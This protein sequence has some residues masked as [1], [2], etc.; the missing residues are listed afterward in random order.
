MTSYRRMACH[1]Q[2]LARAKHYVRLHALETGPTYPDALEVEMGRTFKEFMRDVSRLTVKLQ[3]IRI[4]EP[5]FKTVR[6]DSWLKQT[7]PES[8]QHRERG[9]TGAWE[10]HTDGRHRRCAECREPMRPLGH[11][12]SRPA[13]TEPEASTTTVTECPECLKLG[14]PVTK[15]GAIRSHYRIEQCSGSGKAPTETG[16][17]AECTHPRTPITDQGVLQNHSRGVKCPGSG[18]CTS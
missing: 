16:A 5:A 12:E 1:P 6:P 3:Q 15:R 11:G 10:L 18:R 13:W 2:A 7:D 17:C 9:C 4:P 8:W 14:V